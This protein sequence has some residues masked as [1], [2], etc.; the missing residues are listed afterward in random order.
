MDLLT[1][2][3]FRLTVYGVVIVALAIFAKYMEFRQG[4]KQ[5]RPRKRQ[6]VAYQLRKKINIPSN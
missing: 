5:A 2:E 1:E 3:Q 6:K 4:K